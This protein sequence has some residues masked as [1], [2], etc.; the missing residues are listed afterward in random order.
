MQTVPHEKVLNLAKIFYV[1]LSNNGKESQSVM[2]QN[3]YLD[4]WKV[5]KEEISQAAEENTERL[6]PVKIENLKDI[7]ARLVCYGI[8]SKE[9]ETKILDSLVEEDIRYD[10]YVLSNQSMMNGAAAMLYSNILKLFA[11][12]I[13]SDLII[14][15]CSIH[16]I[17]LMPYI[18]VD[19]DSY[20][21]MV[22][23]VNRTELTQ[24]EI[25]SDCVYIYRRE[26]DNIEIA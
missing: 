14:L 22:K 9:E 12:K 1:M 23:A 2:I 20:K 13:E 10:L 26:T 18:D 4:L 3:A 16:E 5:T 11:D 15:P 17:L 21:E 19:M 6:F 8:C 25:L 7:L 24:E